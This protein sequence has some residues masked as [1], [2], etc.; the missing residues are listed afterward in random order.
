MVHPDWLESLG[1]GRGVEGK[2]KLDFY[3]PLRIIIGSQEK[4]KETL[5][6]RQLEYVVVY[7]PK[8]RSDMPIRDGLLT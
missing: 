7:T 8:I 5:Q 4:K 2:G 3:T 6:C 1:G